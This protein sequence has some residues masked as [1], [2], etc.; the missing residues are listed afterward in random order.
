ME[1]DMK[2]MRDENGCR[3]PKIGT[4]SRSIYDLMK[5]GKRPKEIATETGFKSNNVRVLM[6]K[7]RHPKNKGTKQ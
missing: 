2:S 5:A 6:W 1:S 7:M 4:K 3:V